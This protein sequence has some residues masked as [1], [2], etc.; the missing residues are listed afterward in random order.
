MTLRVYVVPLQIL[1][2]IHKLALTLN[3]RTA[4]ID[5]DAVAVFGRWIK[6]VQ[7]GSSAVDDA[8]TICGGMTDVIGLVLCVAT[9]ILTRR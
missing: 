1:A 8:L 2:C 3:P 9:E 5:C 7:I 6:E 4:K